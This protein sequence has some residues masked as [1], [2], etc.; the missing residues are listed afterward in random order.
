MSFQ[1]AAAV[2]IKI[3]EMELEYVEYIWKQRMRNNTKSKTIFC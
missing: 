1:D 3:Y 2:T